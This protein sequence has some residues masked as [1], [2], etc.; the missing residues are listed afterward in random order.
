MKKNR[1]YRNGLLV[2]FLLVRVV[3][4]SFRQK[5]TIVLYTFLEVHNTEMHELTVIPFVFIFCLFQVY[6]GTDICPIL[7]L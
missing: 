5:L 1:K 6:A 4:Y 7:A 3:G 2:I